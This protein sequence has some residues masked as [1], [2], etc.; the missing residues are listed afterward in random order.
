MDL[1]MFRGVCILVVIALTLQETAAWMEASIGPNDQILHH[2]D[3]G[4]YEG[5]CWAYCTPVIKKS[6]CKEIGYCFVKP[7]KA[8]FQ[9]YEECGADY[10]CAPELSCRSRCTCAR[11]LY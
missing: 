1:S 8:Y 6:F 4:C 5:K 11:L 9:W 7:S 2:G 3:Y 10:D